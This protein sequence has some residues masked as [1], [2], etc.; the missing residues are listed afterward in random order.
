MLVKTAVC[1]NAIMCQKC[2]RYHAPNV[3]CAKVFTIASCEKQ[4]VLAVGMEGDGSLSGPSG[5]SINTKE[6]CK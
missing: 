4:T 2:S 1:E 6:W 3:D 5:L